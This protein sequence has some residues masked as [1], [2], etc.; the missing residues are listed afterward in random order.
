[1]DSGQFDGS[2]SVG[3]DPDNQRKRKGGAAVSSEGLGRRDLLGCALPKARRPPGAVRDVKV[4]SHPQTRRSCRSCC[5]DGR[6]APARLAARATTERLDL[7]YT[8]QWQ[9][10]SSASTLP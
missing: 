9:P 2:H 1:M 5:R 8:S 4:D 7:K 3:C 6:P 10:R